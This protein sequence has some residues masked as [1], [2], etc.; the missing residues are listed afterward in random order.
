MTKEEFN[1]KVSEMC[2][3]VKQHECDNIRDELVRRNIRDPFTYGAWCEKN[4]EANLREDYERKTTYTSDFSIAEWCVPVEGIQA[5]ASTLRNALT[6]W[7]DN[8]EFFAEIIIVL[9][10]KAWEHSARGNH[11]YAEM[12][13]EL[14]LDAKCLYFDWFASDNKQH[15]KAMD[16]YYQY[17]D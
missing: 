17:V 15:D 7:R 8:I 16:Y 4:F 2:A 14:Y 9:N 1:D 10:M 12:Y 5:I 6:N 11:Q 13:S 3:Y